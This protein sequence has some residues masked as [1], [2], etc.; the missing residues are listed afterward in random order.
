MA[1]NALVEFA[2]NWVQ[3]VFGPG[4]HYLDEQGSLFNMVFEFV[5]LVVFEMIY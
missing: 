1:E 4:E 2:F 3:K 5:K